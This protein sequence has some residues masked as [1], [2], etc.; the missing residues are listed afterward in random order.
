MLATYFSFN[1]DPE[2]SRAHGNLAYYNE[3]A[4]NSETQKKGD[5]GVMTSELQAALFVEKPEAD[6][7]KI[8][9]ERLCRGEHVK[10]GI[11]FSI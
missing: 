6:S 2:H 1:K 7:E 5:N 10:V 8:E 4:K 3:A 11:K 9:Y